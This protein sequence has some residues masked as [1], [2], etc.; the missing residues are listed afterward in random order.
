[1]RWCII[2][3]GLF[4]PIGVAGYADEPTDAEI[5]DQL[6]QDSIAR[7]TGS[8][9]CPYHDKWN[10]KLFRS[11]NNFRDHPT[12]KCGSDSEYVRPGGTTVFC[13]GSDVPAE[14][15]A[16]RREHL[17]STFLTEPQPKF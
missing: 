6:V 14:L 13:Y 1:M 8:C 3:L 4:L 5:R 9:A 17:Q 7:Y 15:I 10:E 12:R 2:I 11:P 16:A